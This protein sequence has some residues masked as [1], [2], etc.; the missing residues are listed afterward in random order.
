[1]RVAACGDAQMPD[2]SQALRYGQG[3]LRAKSGPT[4]DRMQS[5]ERICVTRITKSLWFT[6]E[7][8]EPD[9]TMRQFAVYK[10]GRSVFI[11]DPGFQEH[12]CQRSIRT[13]SSVKREIF[14]VF[15]TSITRVDMH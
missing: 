1:V 14:H 5:P 15:R 4:A 12:A 3:T 13:L 6:A 8:Q 9:G 11:R 7:G 2:E 10:K